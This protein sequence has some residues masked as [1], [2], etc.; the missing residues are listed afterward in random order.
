MRYF[1]GTSVFLLIAS[2]LFAND[3]PPVT[4]PRSTSG[5]SAVEPDW[6]QR[7]T[8]TVG[9]KD[10]DIIG[11]TDKSIQAAVDYVTR[12]GG[13]TVKI[14]PG[15]Y[16]LR[17]SV[18]LSSKVRLVGA[19]VETILVKEPSRTTKLA[20][21]SDWYDQEI[22]LAD[23]AGFQ[24]GD[25]I[26]LRARGDGKTYDTYIKRTL[27]ART[28]SRFKL[29]RPLR[30][31]FWRLGNAVAISVF[32]LVTGETVN[33][34]AIENLVLDGNRAKNENLNGNYGGCI[35]FQDCN[36]IAIRGVT[37]RNYN[38]DGISWQICH[39][40]LVENCVS[41]NNAQL[42]LHPG[43]GSQRPIM[44]NNKLKH[45]DI[46]I[47][48]CWGVKYGLAEKN[49]I[50]GNRVGISIGHRDTDNLITLNEI[51]ASKE[52]GILFRPERGKDFAGHR[53][54]IVKNRLIDNGGA[55]GSAIDIQG[56]TE[57]IQILDN[58]IAE[59][60][61]PAQRVAVRVGINTR[62]ITVKGNT[63]RGFAKETEEGKR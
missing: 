56:G 8:V 32:P 16:R 15:T 61:E 54:R 30:D 4:Q 36:R 12:F 7:L 53:N 23:A 14:L 44:R 39:D 55:N 37:T 49:H 20:A 57:A 5:D 33:D 35:F 1:C 3:R 21:D 28:G 42:G 26:T 38:G 34:L 24:V 59:T 9:H 13:G 63:I 18:Y 51:R 2:S 31:N 27:I 60:R 29:D 62:E 50:E 41:E 11:S 19:G 10:A 17:N 47:F 25:G 46:G 40:V 48:F 52:V 45:N 58:E 43:S 6:A 22:T